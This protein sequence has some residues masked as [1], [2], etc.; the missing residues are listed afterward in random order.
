MFSGIFAH[1]NKVSYLNSKSQH[2]AK[3]IQIKNNDLQFFLLIK[4]H[5]L[6]T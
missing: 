4:K 1:S 6:S 2:K 3:K 5:F